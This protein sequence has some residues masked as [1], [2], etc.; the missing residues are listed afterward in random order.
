MSDDKKFTYRICCDEIPAL[1]AFITSLKSEPR[2]II[3]FR[4]QS[5]AE[6]LGSFFYK[7]A[8]IIHED[9]GVHVF[10]ADLM[11]SSEEEVIHTKAEA[12][13]WLCD[14]VFIEFAGGRR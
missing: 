3:K 6:S 14:G 8:E 4:Q 12:I 9:Y 10:Q 11:L 5:S 1:P 2:P 13:G 7:F